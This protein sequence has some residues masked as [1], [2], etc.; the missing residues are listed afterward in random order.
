MEKLKFEMFDLS[1]EGC[2]RHPLVMNPR[3]FEDLIAWQKA[4]QMVSKIYELTRDASLVRDFGLCAQLQRAA[5]S[6]M[7]NIAEGFER[8]HVPEKMQAYNIARGSTAEVRSLLYVVEDNFPIIAP[9]ASLLRTEAIESGKLVSGLLR[10]TSR[11]T[12]G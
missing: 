5:V 8:L 4:R 1:M 7:S 12:C 11:R 10:A 2:I 9:Q 3:T 6:V